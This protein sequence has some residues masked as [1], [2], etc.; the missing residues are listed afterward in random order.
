MRDD[1]NQDPNGQSRWSAAP[2]AQPR[3]VL[4]AIVIGTTVVTVAVQWLATRG[5]A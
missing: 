1:M 4:V 5:W 3:T 2:H